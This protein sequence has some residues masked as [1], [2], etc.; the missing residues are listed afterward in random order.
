MAPRVSSI[1]RRDNV[2]DWSPGGVSSIPGFGSPLCGHGLFIGSSARRG[3][4]EADAAQ[5]LDRHLPD[6]LQRL[7]IELRALVSLEELE[8]R[9]HQLEQRLVFG[10]PVE[11]PPALLS[12]EHKPGA[13]Q[14]EK[15]PGDGRGGQLENG[16]HLADAERAFPKHGQDA[17]ASWVRER[18]GDID[19][20]AK[21]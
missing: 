13:P 17:E 16:R 1:A 8:E 3:G 5:H 9:L 4:F 6:A 12:F 11:D 21:Y 7:G 2:R 10:K 18:L 19:C 14:F 15:V 20:L